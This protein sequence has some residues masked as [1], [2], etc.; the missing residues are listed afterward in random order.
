MLARLWKVI[1]ALLLEVATEDPAT[2]AQFGPSMQSVP[3]NPDECCWIIQ[4]GE[5][6]G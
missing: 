1:E 3:C 2:H 5:Q 4:C 6:C